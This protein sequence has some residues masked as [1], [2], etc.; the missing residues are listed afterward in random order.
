[1]LAVEAPC[2]EVGVVLL[3]PLAAHGGDLGRLI[4]MTTSGSVHA[5]PLHGH[6]WCACQFY[7]NFFKKKNWAKSCQNFCDLKKNVTACRGKCHGDIIISLI[8]YSHF[9]TVIYIFKN[10]V[11]HRFIMVLTV[12]R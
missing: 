6:E 5:R 4:H 9:S 10:K 8:I 2:R 1:M 7:L 3:R 11:S 12:I